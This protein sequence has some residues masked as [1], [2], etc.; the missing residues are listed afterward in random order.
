MK[1]WLTVLLVVFSDAAGN[2]ANRQGMM[3]VGEMT[4]GHPRQIVSLLGRL[5][6]NRLLGVGVL[7]MAFAFFLFLALLS[8]ANLSFVLP[9]TSMGYAVNTLGAQFILKEK[10]TAQRWIGTIFICVGIVLISLSPT[11]R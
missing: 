9:A 3:Q 4:V 5:M 7:F 1:T 8:W 11:G 2:I 10:V 6:T